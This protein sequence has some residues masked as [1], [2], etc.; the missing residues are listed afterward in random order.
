MKVTKS[1]WKGPYED[2]ITFS[3]LS[4][5]I[6]CRERFRLYTIEGLQPEKGFNHR[7]QYGNMWHVCEEH[8]AKGKDWKEP[9]K[10][11]CKGLC[12][13]YPLEQSHISQWYNVCLIQFPIYVEHWK[14]QKDVLDRKSVFQE[15]VFDVK[16]HLQCNDRI[17]RL[18]GKWDSVDLIGR[19]DKRLYIQ[20]NK[21]KGDINESQILK[22]LPFDLQ[23]MIYMLSLQ[24]T[25]T[26]MP[27]HKLL[28]YPLGGIRYNVIRRPLSGGKGTIVQHKPTKKNP[29]G[30]SKEEYYSRLGDIIKEN[31][32]YFFMRWKVEF[33]ATDVTNFCKMCLNPLLEQLCDWWEWMEHNEFD[34]KRAKRNKYHWQHPYG[35]YNVLDEGGS[36]DYDEYLRGQGRSGLVDV[37]SLF[38]ELET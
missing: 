32:S 30:E 3:L 38:T 37:T 10:Q 25:K 12:T 19:S 23:S 9:L 2:G 28:Q 33:N 18:R 31:A 15:K 6:N 26:S 17:V 13:Q 20:E 34:I 27:L 24:L 35:V 8:L 14:G 36:T 16:Y 21:S 11:Y 5:F 7:I 4:K 1:V 22:Q 29:S